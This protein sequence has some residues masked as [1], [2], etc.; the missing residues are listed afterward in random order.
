M[1]NSR[2]LGGIAAI[3]TLVAAAF[4][5]SALPV[6]SSDHQDTPAMINRPAADITDVYVFPSPTNANNVVLV[7]D[8]NPLIP[9]GMGTTKQFDPAVLYQFKI[10]HGPALGN[11]APEDTV[12]QFLAQGTGT[13][14]TL[15][16][17]G[18][19]APRQTGTSSLVLGS[20][21]GSVTYNQAST[22]GNGMQV[23][24]GPRADPFFF[25]LF[26]FFN[27]IPDRFY[28]YHPNP[29]NGPAPVA[30]PAPSPGQVNFSSFG[31]GIGPGQ[32]PPNSFRGFTAAFN[33]ANG[34][35]C[36]T[37]PSADALSSNKFNVL[38]IVA[39]VPKTLLTSSTSSIIHVWATTST[40][41]GS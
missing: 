15:S 40:T 14:Q 37:S 27:I 35:S 31:G 36:S 6:R 41:T 28:G 25:D 3:S 5:Y 12:I 24:A 26:A 17:Y 33:A 38:S 10:S 19:G 32:V 29:P 30:S 20:Q 23:F 1:P 16:V 18:P 34:T 13:G 8:V 21:A 39:E 9:P 4:L 11:T 22:L 2:L 7:M